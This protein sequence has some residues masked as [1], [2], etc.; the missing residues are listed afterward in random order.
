MTDSVAAIRRDMDE[1]ERLADIVLKAQSLLWERLDRAFE[2]GFEDGRIARPPVC[3][4]QGSWAFYSYERDPYMLTYA[5]SCAEHWEEPRKVT[6]S[7]SVID[8][9]L[10][11]MERG[12]A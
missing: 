3:C 10:A 7:P 1:L 6:V 2:L 11:R 5:V 4:D 9:Q 12:E 8:D